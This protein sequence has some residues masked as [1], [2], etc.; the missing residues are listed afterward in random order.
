MTYR[1]LLSVLLICADRHAAWSQEDAT[2]PST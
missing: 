1:N 2:D